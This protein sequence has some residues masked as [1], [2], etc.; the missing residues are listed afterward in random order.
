M[1]AT[2]QDNLW[3][4]EQKKISSW[5]SL[6]L[7]DHWKKLAFPRTCFLF[8]KHIPIHQYWREDV[9]VGMTC[10]EDF[11]EEAAALRGFMII[12]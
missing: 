1:D 9:T 8:F 5:S 2:F 11:P 7:W 12:L 3:T 10:W 4:F 6:H